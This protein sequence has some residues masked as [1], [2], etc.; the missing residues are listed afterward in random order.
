MG[1]A[2]SLDEI[3]GLMSQALALREIDGESAEF[4]V[5]DFMESEIEGHK[6]HGLSKFLTI[7]IGIK[8]R[9]DGL[10][11]V[12]KSGCFAKIDGNR[13][14]GHIAALKATNMAISLAKE[15]G[16]GIVALSNNSR[17]S[18]IT[19]YGRKIAREGLVGMITN[20]G[21]PAAVA[22]FGGVTGMLGTNPLC[23]S[24]PSKGERPYVFDFSTAQR[25]WGEV[26]QAI[27]EKRPLPPNS[28][29]DKEGN[30]T[31]EP[32]DAQAVIPFGGPKG[33]AL[34]YALEVMSGAF[35]GA[36]MGPA[37]KDE[38]DLG[39]LFLAFSPDMFT[40]LETFTAEMDGMA[41]E[42]RDCRPIQ[43]GGRVFVPGEIFKEKPISQLP[44]DSIE[45]EEE[46]YERLKIMSVSLEGGY[47]NSKHLN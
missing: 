34:C 31:T 43:E 42:I 9:R 46:V 41:Q 28:F 29:L 17:Y 7:D 44:A 6:T 2:V 37:V 12:K 14:L 10:K 19:P 25:V 40:D 39:Y 13:E 20:N 30:F 24:F 5:A 45:I 15:H 4:I 11:I 36:K 22:P 16:V 33:Y 38:Y 47:E 21:G 18:R 23:F 1:V 27:V 8:E 32:Y 3:R 35:I 26:R